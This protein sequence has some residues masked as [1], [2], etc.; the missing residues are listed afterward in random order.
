[1]DIRLLSCLAGLVVLG[2]VGCASGDSYTD[3]SYNFSGVKKVAVVDVQG[4]V[5]GQG[6][7]NYVADQIA[8]QLLQKGY[9]PIERS[10]VQALLKEQKFE[11]SAATT[12]EGAIE[13]GRLLNVDAVMMVNIM[14]YGSRIELTAKMVDPESG[15]IVWIGNGSASTG[16]KLPTIAGAAIGAGTGAALG[17]SRS[18]R[19][20]GGGVGGALGGVAGSAL[21]PAE[22]TQFKKAVSKAFKDLPR[23]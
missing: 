1:M 23:G 21:T 9:E 19:W 2:A 8:I 15:K 16:G 14:E 17:G 13:V 11:A 12:K 4:R 7:Q 18:G 10:Q 20:I 5:G 22:T 6:G 3:S